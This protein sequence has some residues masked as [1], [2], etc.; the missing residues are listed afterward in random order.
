MGTTGR[1]EVGHARGDVEREGVAG[2]LAELEVGAGE[3]DL[4]G[5]AADVLG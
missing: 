3:E 4:E 2:R 5:T 1:V